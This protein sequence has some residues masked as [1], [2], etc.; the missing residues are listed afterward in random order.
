MFR[1]LGECSVTFEK[2]EEVS[3]AGVWKPY[4]TTGAFTPV[5]PLFA[6]VVKQDSQMNWTLLIIRKIKLYLVEKYASACF[7]I[8]SHILDIPSYKSQNSQG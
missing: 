5:G 4:I 1:L 3:T 8:S 6:P 7:L 2:V